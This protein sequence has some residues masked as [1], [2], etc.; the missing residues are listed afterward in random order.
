MINQKVVLETEANF[1]NNDA[2][3]ENVKGKKKLKKMR[4]IRLVKCSSMKSSIREKKSPNYMKGTSS[5]HAKESLQITQTLSTKK[6]LT[7]VYTLKLK[8]NVTRKSEMKKKLKSS[9]SMKFATFKSQKSTSKKSESESESTSSDIQLQSTYVGNKSQRVITRKLSLKPVRFLA[10]MPTFKSKNDSVLHKATCSSTLKDFHFPDH[11]DLPQEESGSQGVPAIRVCPYTYCSLHGRRHGDLPP[12]KR[13]VSMRRRQLRTQKSTKMDDYDRS[14]NR[15]K[16]IGNSRKATQQSRSVQNVKKLA[17]DSGIRPRDTPKTAVTEGGTSGGE[18]EEMHKFRCDTEVFPNMT[19]IEQ[20]LGNSLAVKGSISPSIKDTN[21]RSCCIATVKD[22]SDSEVTKSANDKNIAASKK[23]DESAIVESTSIDLLKSSASDIEILEEEATTKVYEVTQTSSAPK[24]PE[25]VC[26][27]DVTYKTQERDQK[28]IKKW[29]LMYKHAILSITGKENHKLPFNGRDKEGRGRDSHT[30]NVGNRSS[31]QDC[32]ETGQDVDDENENVIDQMQKAFDEILLQEPEDLFYDDDSKSRGIGS[33]EVFLEKSEG[34]GGKLYN[35]ASRK[36]PKEETWPEVDNFGSRVEEITAQKIG[37]KAEQKTPKR[38]SNLKKLILLRRFVK[39][40]E[41]VRNFNL[42]RPRHLPSDANFE[43]EKVFLK[44]QTAEEKKNAEEWMLDYALRT[45]ISR[46]EPAQRRKVALLAEA[47]ETILPFQDAANG[48]QSLATKENRAN[49]SQSLDDSSY[50]SKEETD[51]GKD[52]G[53]SSNILLG[54]ALS[55]HNSVTG[56]ADN[57]SD[58][59]MPELHNPEAK[60]VKDMPVSGAIDEDFIGKQSLTRNYDNEEKISSDNDNIHLEEIKDSR[61]W[62][63]SELPEIVGNCNEEATTSE[64]VN[65]VADDSESTSNTEI[66]N[67]KPQSPGREFETKN[68]IDADT[69]QFSMTKSLILKGL[70][71]LLG[72]NS[73]GSGAPSDQLD[74]PTLDRKERIEKARLETGTPEGLAAPAQSRAPKRADVAEPETDIEKHKLWYLVYKHMVSDSAEDDTKMLVDGAEEKESGNEGGR[75]RGTSVSYDSTPVMNEDLQ[76]QGHGVANRE[77]ELQQLEAIKM[78]EDAIDSITSDVQDQLPDR[79]SLGDNTISDDCSKQSNR[80]ERVHS[81][82]LNQKQEK[83]ELENE[84]A[85]EQEQAAPKE[86][87][88]PN[89]QLSKSWS[90]LRKVVLLRR[91][92]KALEK[93]RKFNPRGPRYL[94]IEPDSE[95][96]KV[97]LRH[98]DMLGRKGTEEWMLD[99]ALQRVVSR[100]TPERKRKVGLLV[101]AFETIMPTFKN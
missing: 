85:E 99:Y 3:S 64:I 98:Q 88:K 97:N 68:L 81:E 56:F 9:R 24:E 90:N 70:P 72:S 23:N 16:Q 54:K 67:S 69:E 86:G 45:V 94:P 17:S 22:T 92:I 62:S 55:S 50:D 76:S 6:S 46:L 39:A 5:S 74:E 65:E 32:C 33:D 48:L 29:H 52:C 71:R 100:L 30:L 84:I 80:T 40:L 73:V 91:F 63:L 60:M 77:V 27:T 61:S 7:R 87:N 44:H 28:Y 31:C 12:L 96:E 42:Q 78:V 11:I 26:D 25:P 38:W 13:F 101:E 36:S 79:Q 35:S 82:G 14:V 83:M 18:G 10:K 15:L 43:A 58:D 21:M 59:P 95:A 93:V 34:D 41:K 75:I 49:P 47:F 66:P 2:K 89:Q 19:N 37:A 1:S 20:D 51:K 4:S 53:Y 8:K 57:A